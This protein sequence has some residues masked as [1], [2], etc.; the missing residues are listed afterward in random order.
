MQSLHEIRPP[1]KVTWRETGFSS[2]LFVEKDNKHGFWACYTTQN[3]PPTL[4]NHYAITTTPI[5]YCTNCKKWA[6]NNG[7]SA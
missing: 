4:A 3:V 5:M 2:H 1:L 6:E 7:I